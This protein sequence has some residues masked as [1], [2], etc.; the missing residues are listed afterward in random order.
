MDGFE[1]AELADCLRSPD[2]GRFLRLLILHRTASDAFSTVRLSEAM[3]GAPDGLVAVLAAIW[4]RDEKTA[5]AILSSPAGDRLGR[6]RDVDSG[7]TL[8]HLAALRGVCA[9]F[10][11]LISKLRPDP[12][13]RNGVTPILL[14]AACNDGGK[15][16]SAL[17]D[18]G[19]DVRVRAN[20]DGYSE[21]VLPHL[22]MS[23]RYGKRTG[24]DLIWKVLKAGAP[25]DLR[26]YSAER[27]VAMAAAFY[28]D[29]QVFHYILQGLT[30]PA[31][32]LAEVDDGGWTA[33]SI[34]TFSNA[35]KIG[36]T[37]LEH[38]GAASPAGSIIA[39]LQIA[40]AQLAPEILDLLLK[41]FAADNGRRLPT[42]PD[43]RALRRGIS[44]AYFGP[45]SSDEAIAALDDPK[46]AQI[47]Q[48]RFNVLRVASEHGVVLDEDPWPLAGAFSIDRSGGVNTSALIREILHIRGKHRLRII[49]TALANQMTHW[50]QTSAIVA[51][52]TLSAAID[53]V[54][55]SREGLTLAHLF[56]AHWDAEADKGNGSSPFE[57]L[58]AAGLDIAAQDANG[59]TALHVAA[60]AGN[61]AAAT[62]LLDLDPT[63]TSIASADGVLPADLVGHGEREKNAELAELV[64]DAQVWSPAPV[65]QDPEALEPEETIGLSLMPAD[66]V[67]EP[68]DRPLP[69]R[70]VAS[71]G[72]QSA[73]FNPYAL[74]FPRSPGFW[75]PLMQ[76]WTE[77]PY[78]DP[79]RLVETWWRRSDGTLGM[80]G[81]CEND[82][83]KLICNLNGTSPPIHVMNAERKPAFHSDRAVQ[84]YLHFFC[85][86]VRGDDGNFASIY[87]DVK[88]RCLG[89]ESRPDHRPL[90]P[91]VET[92]APR[93]DGDGVA[94]QRR[95]R[96]SS[97][98]LYSGTVFRAEFEI[99]QSGMVE[100]IEDEPVED[101]TVDTASC[102]DGG[103]MYRI[104]V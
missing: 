97:L 96:A 9:V 31:R 55:T 28:G 50:F 35:I 15:S 68:L 93:D 22:L 10:A 71:E 95:F 86:A 52:E 48:A 30:D 14:A 17:L 45:E 32:E 38:V 39:P 87:S 40:A 94:D 81:H 63:L 58:Q 84:D 67:W 89:L 11:T 33:L 7:L 6:W 18:R 4:N 1:E 3:P 34:A 80:S 99:Q 61:L 47:E 20:L 60:A 27:T 77:L 73:D 88:R 51:D 65:S 91:E 24:E 103:I 70:R 13:D 90:I 43:F 42:H 74:P 29:P 5:T 76:R 8:L 26:T 98:V 49:H 54:Q 66:T 53:P 36:E 2:P 37:C 104:E 85:S 79:V 78:R 57:R 59:Y 69:R 21:G 102:F 62:T 101:W 25:L 75:T 12:Q 83:N 64:A 19:A 100:M 44:F 92:I 41:W 16:L 82:D 56:A 72:G 23:G 46:K